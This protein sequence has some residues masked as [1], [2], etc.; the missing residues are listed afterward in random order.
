[1]SDLKYE[2]VAKL[3]RDVTVRD[4][5]SDDPERISAALY[6]ATY[7][8]PDWRWVQDECLR[9][10]THENL[11][12]RWTAATCLGDLAMFHETLDLARVLPALLE[13]CKDQSIRDPA[14]VSISFIKHAVK[15][16]KPVQ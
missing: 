5:S 13:A 1:M 10:L 8:D 6:S 4:L 2:P 3:P 16:G 14:E 15:T 7:Y 11:L 12:V 9:F